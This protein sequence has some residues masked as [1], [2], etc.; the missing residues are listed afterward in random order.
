MLLKKKRQLLFNGGRG[1]WNIKNLPG[2]LAVIE[3]PRAGTSTGFTLANTNQ[4]T[5]Y[6]DPVTGAAFS[7]YVNNTTY[8]ELNANA[9]PV[10]GYDAID[11]RH[12]GLEALGTLVNASL[13]VTGNHDY[14]MSSYMQMTA[15]SALPGGGSIPN[16]IQFGQIDASKTN[17]IG[18]DAGGS[19]FRVGANDAFSFGTFDTN[20]HYFEF[21]HDSA[22]SIGRIYIDGSYVTEATVSSSLAVGLGIGNWTSTAKTQQALIYSTKWGSQKP[23]FAM[24]KNIAARDIQKFP[25]LIQ[26]KHINT[27]GD[28]LLLGYTPGVSTTSVADIL[29]AR[30][31]ALTPAKTITVK[32]SSIGGQSIAYYDPANGHIPTS[33]FEDYNILAP[34]N[35]ICI[36]MGKND[37][38]FA[39]SNTVDTQPHRDTLADAM[40]VSMQAVLAP[41]IAYGWKI[42]LATITPYGIAAVSANHELTRVQYNNKL[43]ALGAAA[44]G[45]TA[46]VDSD[47]VIDPDCVNHIPDGVHYDNIGQ[48][49]FATIF[50]TPIDNL[51]LI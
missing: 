30:Y 20:K 26:P 38:S 36:C 43:L 14:Y 7:C 45:V 18:T 8:C 10:D 24:R 39:P 42:I 5:G 2:L 9:N 1:Q 22:T 6:I 44:L 37:I 41:W 46:L 13:G 35:V 12:L 25:S 51:N 32:N 49:Y 47:T 11:T 17:G 29:L 50:Q 21:I 19:V 3:G 48:G 4:I 31:A 15:L 27:F 28:S 34:Q 33:R 40:L 16:A 23:T